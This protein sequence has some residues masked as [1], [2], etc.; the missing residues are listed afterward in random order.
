M[1]VAYT[2]FSFAYDPSNSLN[3]YEQAKQ[4][5]LSTPFESP[6]QKALF[7]TPLE[8]WG[9]YCNEIG[10]SRR[11]TYRVERYQTIDDIKNNALINLTIKREDNSSVNIILTS[12][13]VN[14]MEVDAVVNAA[15][16]TLLGGGGVDGEIH[17][18]AGPLLVKECAQFR[19]GCK[20]GEAKITKGYDLP[21]SYVIHT[22]G[23]LLLKQNEPDKASLSLCY[24]SCFKICEE[25]RLSSIAFPCIACGFYAFPI[26]VSAQIVKKEINRFV[27]AMSQ[28]V[29][30][31]ILS[32]PAEH[33]KTAYMSEFHK[34]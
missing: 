28:N 5:A 15:N 34:E 29:K 20:V 25:F 11:K 3:Y 17:R 26:H 7:E 18:A 32:L 2:G 6:D 4:A 33:E 9:S 21:A 22:V 12:L 27:E 1:S 31:I 19:E 13:P 8:N 16:E 30:T 10:E 24:R 14:Q 23:P